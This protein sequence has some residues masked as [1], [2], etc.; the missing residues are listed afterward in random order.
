MK[1]ILFSDTYDLISPDG[2]VR[3]VQKVCA[4]TSSHYTDCL[5][6]EVVFESIS[7]NFVGFSIDT[8]HVEFNLK[9]TLAQLGME[10]ILLF[11]DIDR[12][13]LRAFC[14]LLLKPYGALAEELLSHIVEGVSLGKLFAA[15]PNRRVRDPEYLH[16][17]F[18]RSDQKGRP[19]LSLGGRQG[20][21][22]LILEKIDG[23]TIAYL[24]LK[25][26]VTRYKDSIQ[27]LLPTIG[28]ALKNRVSVRHLLNL[29][30]Y[31]DKKSARVVKQNEILLTR[32]TPLHI[33]T[34][35]A[36]VVDDF[37]PAGFKHTSA[38]ILDPS[39]EASGDIYE[40]YGSCDSELTDIPLEFYTLEP[41]RE[42]IFFKD[43]DQLQNS[44]EKSELLFEAFR[45]APS[46]PKERAAVFI[47]KGAQL[48][49][50]KTSDWLSCQIHRHQFPGILHSARQA[51]MVEHYIEQQP[52][53]LFLKSIELGHIT[54]QGI[55]LTKYF[56]S[57]LMKRMLLSNRVLQ[58]LKAL[59]FYKPSQN[60]GSFFSHEDH[61][62]LS[63]L[64]RFAVPVYWV[65]ESSGNILQYVQ[66]TENS[67]GLFT[68][69]HQASTYV[70]STVFGIY[71]SNLLNGGFEK[72]L[73]EL[74]KGLLDMRKSS[75]HP[76]L[77]AQTSLS[78]VTG[79]GPG[80]METGN[81][82]AKNLSILSCA[83]IADFTQK[84]RVVNEQR[85]NPYVEAKMT[86]RLDKLVERQADFNLD[87]PIFVMGGIG[88]DFE[89]HL[90][91]VRRKTG[92]V[93]ARPILLFGPPDYWHDKIA[94][95]YQRNDKTGTIK[96]SEWISRCY[97][98]IQTAA[99]GLAVYKAYFNNKLEIG[100]AFG[101]D[102]RGF[103]IVDDSWKP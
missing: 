7:P 61:A 1:Q 51:L 81:R 94:T 66:K 71:G 89:F 6:A 84:G 97:Y 55:L 83:H 28:L 102:P 36:R 54:S 5:E 10:A 67:T 87:F 38:R 3:K 15:D 18:G 82:V 58:C 68:P 17:M 41:H 48:K 11:L 77:N 78:L 52:E 62:V 24:S 23:R 29:H 63:D 56:P 39:T 22:D 25:E 26:G 46:D 19:L 93:P 101:N 103:V 33:R 14:T 44:L 65:D 64:W 70:K 30:Q 69:L 8:I 50:L 49:E 88:T 12:S 73:T 79:G 72:E 2:L 35:F 32:T 21:N 91:Q 13:K 9:S 59:Y 57:P 85:Q 45:K 75:N 86:Y 92:A 74:L 43:R 4:E 16:R 96:G 80:A 76:Q 47:V 34:A 42:H 37:L 98:V 100:P 90:E 99:Q 53:Y 31:M 27:G 60:Y 95:A 40:L 20:S